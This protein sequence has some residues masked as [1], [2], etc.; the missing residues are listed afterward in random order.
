MAKK[1]IIIFVISIFYNLSFAQRLLTN[2]LVIN[3]SFESYTQ[4]PDNVAQI[5]RAFPW[6]DC[7]GG[8][9]SDFYHSCCSLNWMIQVLNMQHPRT[10][11]GEAGIYVY[12]LWIDHNYRDYIIDELY[13]YLKNNKKY[14]SE[15]YVSLSNASKGAI[16]NIGMYFSVDTVYNSNGMFPLVNLQ[17][18]IENHNGII[19]DTMNWVKKIHYNR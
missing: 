9:G 2:N 5:K 11:N 18:Q 10:G 16:E 6:S 4:C 13:D 3:P 19:K 15:F 14:C 12:G 7:V 17:P 8:I 1:V